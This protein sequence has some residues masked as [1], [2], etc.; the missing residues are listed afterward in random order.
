MAALGSLVSRGLVGLVL[1]NLGMLH[2]RE[3]RV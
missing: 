3:R 1:V 2:A